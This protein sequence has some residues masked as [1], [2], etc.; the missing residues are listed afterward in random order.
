MTWP[1]ELLKSWYHQRRFVAPD[2]G[3]FQGTSN[4]R[5][6][7]FGYSIYQDLS[8]LRRYTEAM[9]K[10]IVVGQEKLGLPIIS[11]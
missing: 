3:P 2:I 7:L 1:P 10:S 5:I 4:D 11:V 9:C 8:N 6:H